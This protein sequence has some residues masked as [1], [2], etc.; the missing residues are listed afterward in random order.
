LDPNNQRAKDLLSWISSSIP[1]SVHISDAGYTFLA[2]TATPEPPKPFLFV[3]ETPIPSP[4]IEI[5]AS[6]T[7]IPV[8]P[9]ALPTKPPAPAGSPICGGTGLVLPIVLGLL[10]FSKRKMI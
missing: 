4:T 3:T 1:D 8:S 6:P 2:L 9:T 7:T 5:I 10:W